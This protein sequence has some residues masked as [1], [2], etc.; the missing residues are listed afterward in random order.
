MA[1]NGYSR[2]SKT[3][4]ITGRTVGSTIPP[5]TLSTPLPAARDNLLMDLSST[6][7]VTTSSAAAEGPRDPLCQLKSCQPLHSFTKKSR[8][9]DYPA[10]ID[11]TTFTM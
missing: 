2:S 5:G 11:I 7:I 6:G 4:N 1:T 8:Y 9:I 10:L 3:A